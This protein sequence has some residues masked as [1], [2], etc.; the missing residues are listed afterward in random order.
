MTELIKNDP[1]LADALLRHK[2]FVR[3]AHVALTACLDADRRK[4]A[5]RL[6]L[7][8]VKKDDDFAWSGPLI[9]LLNLLPAEEVRPV[10]R[11]QWSNYGLRDALLLRLTDKPEETDREKF[12]TGLDSG[13]EQVVAACLDGAWNACRATTKPLRHAAGAPAAAVDPGT[14]GEGRR[15]QACALLAR[16]TGRPFACQG[17]RRRPGGAEAPL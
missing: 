17:R 14:E 11:E 3:P 5:A 9:E 7:E 2:D 15:T 4:Q 6:F 8:A 12:L 13:Q 16:Q 1:R 10:F